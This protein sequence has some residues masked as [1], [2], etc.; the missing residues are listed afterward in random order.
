MPTD[1]IGGTATHS[2]SWQGA[3]DAYPITAS[4]S[5]SLVSIGMNLFSVNAGSNL[6]LAIYTDSS[7]QPGTLLGQSA[8][9]VGVGGQWN[10]LS[11]T[12]V[13]IVANTPYWLAF[14]AQNGQLEPWR[15][16]SSTTIWQFSQAYGSFPASGS[17]FTNNSGQNVQNLRM[18]Y[19]LTIVSLGLQTPTFPQPALIIQTW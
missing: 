10:D 13:S 11:V 19:N 12:G 14:Q 8:D 3:V 16:A 2:A 18:T 5:G 15:D 17:S 1:T 4:A 9:T 6:R 7:G